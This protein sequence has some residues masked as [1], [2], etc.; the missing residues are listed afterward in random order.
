MIAALS[1]RNIAPKIAGTDRTK[2]QNSSSTTRSEMVFASFR[3][4]DVVLASNSEFWLMLDDI[5][6][7]KFD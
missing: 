4:L 3:Y 1:Y 2:Q 6:T 5:L 7:I